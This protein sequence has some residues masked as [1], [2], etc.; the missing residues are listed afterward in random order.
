MDKHVVLKTIGKCG[1]I[2]DSNCAFI[3]EK[4]KLER[5][6]INRVHWGRLGVIV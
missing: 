5:A 2:K 1:D 3:E 4:G 6:G